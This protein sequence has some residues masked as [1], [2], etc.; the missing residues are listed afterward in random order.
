MAAYPA[1][2]FELIAA[3][4]LVVGGWWIFRCVLTI[5]RGIRSRNWPA[6]TGEIRSVKVAKKFNRRG[7]EIWREELEYKYSVNGTSYRGTRRQFG[8]PA[9]YDWNHGREE[10]YRKG[11]TVD[12]IYNASRP[13]VSALVRGFSPF[14]WIP[15]VVGG[16]IVWCGV[17]LL[18]AD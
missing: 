14:V 3:L 9:R 2:V 16:W 15:L 17:R 7:R 13:S 5:V 6:T 10:P 11:E 8:V 18:L 1:T 12:V 4:F